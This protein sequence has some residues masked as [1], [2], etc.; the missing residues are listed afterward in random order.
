MTIV[1]LSLSTPA[2]PRDSYG[3]ACMPRNWNA[4]E[5]HHVDRVAYGRFRNVYLYITEACQ[6]RCEHCYMGERLE[7][8]LKMNPQQIVDTL[9]VW[10]KMGGDKLTILGGEPT[11][12]PFYVDS[13]KVASKI[14]YGHVITATNAQDAARKKFAKLE[15]SDFAYVQ[16][17]LDGGSAATHDAVR[18]KRTFDIAMETSAELCDRGFD[19]HII[20]TE[21]EVYWPGQDFLTG[22]R[23]QYLT[24]A[25]D[26]LASA[27]STPT[28]A[29]AHDQVTVLTG[30]EVAPQ[31]HQP[32][33]PDGYDGV[34]CEPDA[35]ERARQLLLH[36]TQSVASANKKVWTQVQ[37][38]LVRLVDQASDPQDRIACRVTALL[39]DAIL[40]PDPGE[41]PEAIHRQILSI[42]AA[43]KTVGEP[44][45]HPKPSPR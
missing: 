34:V 12:H 18:G 29:L 35:P 17:S 11:L 28:S 1:P 42:E 14:G 33:Q 22:A 37:K 8:A 20:C 6:L 3:H 26:R 10:R 16:V 38:L 36:R 43:G 44:R 5:P 9:T 23:E 24:L 40:N 4:T 21:F 39:V 30:P 2:A 25:V 31:Q 45:S 27:L 7:R 13:I 32:H 41:D 19:T 15:P